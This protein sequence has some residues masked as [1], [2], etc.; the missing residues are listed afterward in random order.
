[1]IQITY[2]GADITTSVS[3]NRCYHDMY[4]AGRSDT[5]S[6]LVNDVDNLWDRWAP[7][8]GDEIKVDYGA[9]GTGTMFVTKARPRNGKYDIAAQ[10]APATGFEARDKAWRKV[11]LLQIGSEIAARNGLA[12]VSYGVT[13]QLYEYILQTNESDFHFLHRRAKLEGCAFLV[14]D[15]TLVLYNEAYMEA[16][17]ASE[18]L[19]VTEDADYDYNDRRA[20]LYGSCL[21]EN[22]LYT[23]TFAVGN[24]SDRILKPA[25]DFYVGSNAEAARYAK[26][27]LRAANKSCY[28]GF[29]RTR[30]MTGYAAASTVTLS[31]VRAPSW[32]GTVFLDH[33]RNDYGQG[34]S[35][36]FFRRPL[37]GY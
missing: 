1:M 2:K 20:E 17:A 32:D 13:D 21:I 7:A 8:V 15:K 5:L 34:K 27:L 26:G 9:I 6:L 25:A 18:T 22:G 3:I 19:E 33:I 4:A 23:G 36:I 16:Q 24:G 10:S 12:F 35:K 14:Y 31:N 29:V 37:E 30:I 28:G 11:R